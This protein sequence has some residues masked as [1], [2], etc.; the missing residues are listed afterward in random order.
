MTVS[1]SCS[2]RSLPLWSTKTHSVALPLLVSR[3]AGGPPK[4]RIQSDS[5]LRYA[6]LQLRARQARRAVFGSIRA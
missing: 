5:P 3:P 6:T 1:P 2:K 4:A